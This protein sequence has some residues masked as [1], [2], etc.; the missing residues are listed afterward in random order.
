MSASK[1]SRAALGCGLLLLD[2]VAIVVVVMAVAWARLAPPAEAVSASIPVQLG[3]A[4]SDNPRKQRAEAVLL[5]QLH[6]A[7]VPISSRTAVQADALCIVVNA[8]GT[9]NAVAA[10]MIEDLAELTEAQ[11]GTFVET[12]RS[13]LCD[14]QE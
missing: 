8:G 1:G 12:V 2:L 11:A 3:A 4:A 10:E 5:A 6:A 13:T 14:V 9:S 7:N